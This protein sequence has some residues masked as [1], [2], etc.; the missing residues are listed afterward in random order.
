MPLGEAPAARQKLD[1]APPGDEVEDLTVY[2]KRIHPQDQN[3]AP[4]PL[5]LGPATLSGTTRSERPGFSGLTITAA[6]P[7]PGVSG[8]DATLDI[9][10]GHDQVN[11]TTTAVSAAAIAGLKLKF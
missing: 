5:T 9:S 1:L 10:G 6:V 11:P 8:L 3:P 7:V 4:A 2:G